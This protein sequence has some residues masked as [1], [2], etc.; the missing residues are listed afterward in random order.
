MT[1]VITRY[2]TIAHLPLRVRGTWQV[3]NGGAEQEEC[4]LEDTTS[5]VSTEKG[6]EDGVSFA[7]W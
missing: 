3:R 7:S 1:A 5:S 4:P 6:R 2:A